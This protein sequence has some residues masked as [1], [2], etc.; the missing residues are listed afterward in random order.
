MKAHPED[1]LRTV[2][3]ADRPATIR[4]YAAHL[5]V[6]PDWARLALTV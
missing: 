3:L 6:H 5:G 1:I 2:P 4:W